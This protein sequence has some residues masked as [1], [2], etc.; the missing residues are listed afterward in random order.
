MIGSDSIKQEVYI[1]D[2]YK[3]KQCTFEREPRNF[4]DIGANVGWF[5]KLVDE[6]FENCNIFSYE[7]DKDNF[8]NLKENLEHKKN[9][10]LISNTAVIGSNGF[11]RYWKHSSNIGGHKP[12]FEG[13]ESYIS[14]GAMPE[15]ILRDMN[16]R[17]EFVDLEIDKITLREIID[18]NEIDYIDFLKLDC[19]GSE[20][21]ILNHAINH[22]YC[23]KVLNMSAELHGKDYDGYRKLIED[24]K[25]NFDSVKV[26]RNILFATNKIK[27][28]K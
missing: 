13:S 27:K 3:V 8:Y 14:E 15:K 12:I 11:T 25:K 9:N 20:Y 16:H 17:G 6:T 1:S 23:N 28:E 24:L 22:G 26:Q 21:E 5:T 19:E 10:I 2:A 7:L 4:V 18:N